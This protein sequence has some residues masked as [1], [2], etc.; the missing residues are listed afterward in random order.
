M[1]DEDVCEKDSSYVDQK[2]VFIDFKTNVI[3]KKKKK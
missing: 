3:I 2:N 1:N